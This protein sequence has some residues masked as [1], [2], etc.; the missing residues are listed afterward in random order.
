MTP[1]IEESQPFESRRWARLFQGLA[2]P[3]RLQIINALRDGESSV[4]DL[5]RRLHLKQA[6]ASQHLAVLRE[7]RLVQTRRDGQKI[8]YSLATPNIARAIDL[9]SDVDTAKPSS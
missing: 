4:G 5:C 1:L 8:F 7:R 2:D 3:K 9:L 6:N